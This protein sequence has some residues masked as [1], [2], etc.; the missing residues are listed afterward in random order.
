M[1]KFLGGSNVTNM[2][3]HCS[4]AGPKGLVTQ[5]IFLDINDRMKK[6]EELGLSH[7]L[8]K[9]LKEEGFTEPS[10]IQEKTI[11]ILLKGK[12][13]LGGSATGSGKTLAFSVPIIEN[14]KPNQRVQALILTPTRELAEQVA[15]SIKKFSRNK[16]LNVLAVYGG[17]SI[18]PQMRKLAIADVV[19]GTPGRILD[20]MQKRTLRLDNVKFLV[21]DEVDR[22]FDMGFH[23]DVER[24]INECPKDRQTM[25]FSATIS[26]EIDYLAKKYTKNPAEVSVKSYLDASKL[27]QVYY[28]VENHLKFSLLVHLLGKENSD[29]VMV[30]CSTRRNADF[31]VANLARAGINAKAIHGGLDQ[32][33]RKKVLSEFHGKGVGV[34]VCTDV[35]ARGLDIKGV[36]HV[37]NYDLPA[38]SSDYVHRIGRTARAGEE[39]IAINLLSSRDYEN[40][41]NIINNKSLNII[42]K[43]VPRIEKVSITNDFGKKR[44]FRGSGNNNPRGS[45]NRRG[46]SSGSRGGGS[47]E[48]SSGNRNFGRN[49]KSSSAGGRSFGS[50]GRDSSRGNSSR[51]FRGRDGR[52]ESDGKKRFGNRSSGNR[53]FGKRR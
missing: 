46:P 30:F 25:M 1:F 18:E 11:P 34:L 23:R 37:Y 14:L 9:V 22:M 6:F 33:K 41:S 10:E 52:S 3:R 21:L 13:L 19:V 12:D 29:L 40:F 4:G 53:N 20:H 7:E 16:K 8:L 31:V 49:S 2:L 24:I 27:K 47:R 35:A 28:D 5:E 38:S 43:E 32:N 44:N 42:Q 26:D 17:V 15:D 36:S 50:R 51:G 48:R 39:G 45:F